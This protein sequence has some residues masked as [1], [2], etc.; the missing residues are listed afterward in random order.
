MKS[1]KKIQFHILTALPGV[2]DSYFKGGML[3]KALDKKLISVKEHNLHDFSSNKYGSVDDTPY[4]G[5]AGM[6]LQVE[7][8]YKALKRIKNPELRTKKNTRTILFSAAGKRMTQRDV[9]RLS[10]FDQIIFVCGRFEGVDERVLEFVD[11]ELSI[12]DYVL[13]GGELPALVVIDAVS[14]LIPGVLGNVESAKEESHAI[15]GQLEFPQY[16]KPESF[17]YEVRSTKSEGNTKSKN[18]KFKTLSVPE[19]L[20]GGNHELIKQWRESNRKT[21]LR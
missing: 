13:T 4:G 20:R 15:D 1:I 5:G 10:K 9:E 6:V 19:V 14:R 17:K 11:E 18:K 7:P 12:G 2:I 8:I 3:K 16:T 21:R